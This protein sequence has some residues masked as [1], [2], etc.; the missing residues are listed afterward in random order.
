M[1]KEMLESAL[2][3]VEERWIDEAVNYSRQ[4]KRKLYVRLA[5][6]AACLT[7]IAG[8]VGVILYRRNHQP[9]SETPQI[10][11]LQLSDRTTAEIRPADSLEKI[12]VS[13]K[14]ELVYLTEEEL[15]SDPRM[16]AFRGTVVKLD[17]YEIR[18]GIS[19]SYR[20]IAYV[21]AD[22]VYCGDIKPGDIVSI[23]LPCPIGLDGYLQE[24]TSTIQNIRVGGEGIFLPKRY[25][26]E[27]YWSEEDSVVMLNEL[28]MCGLG[29][30]MRHVFLE[31]DNGI[32]YDTNS[33]Q[34]NSPISTLDDAEAYVTE[35]LETYQQ[36]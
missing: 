18:F 20:C 8:A 29:D 28:A 34:P 36:K 25:T 35:M 11:Q 23:L 14:G 6:A 3:G 21:K 1:K 26:A 10:P 32:A 17:N 16:I 13:S 22:T 2:N 7:V 5:A 27:S 4:S 15:F 9:I 33:Y 24:D 31:K 19:T 30:G 12:V